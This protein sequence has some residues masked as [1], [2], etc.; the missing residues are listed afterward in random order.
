VDE[1]F[2]ILRQGRGG[3][4]EEGREGWED[5]GKKGHATRKDSIE[6]EYI[7]I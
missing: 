4:G 7:Y 3:G 2:P 1:L 5:G 6:E